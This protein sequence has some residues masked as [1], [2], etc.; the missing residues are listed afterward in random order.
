MLGGFVSND[1]E[2][3]AK[4]KDGLWV[5]SR[6]DVETGTL[7]L[8][9]QERRVVNG[10][11]VITLDENGGIARSTPLAS[12]DWTRDPWVQVV[13]LSVDEWVSTGT[14]PKGLVGKCLRGWM[15]HSSRMLCGGWGDDASEVGSWFEQPW[16][17][18]WMT[19]DVTY[20]VHR[21]LGP[22]KEMDGLKFT[23]DELRDGELEGEI[24]VDGDENPYHLKI[25]YEQIAAWTLISALP[26]V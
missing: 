13:A 10:G 22:Y 20:L 1:K 11:E 21:P 17:G 5:R 8:S 14:I 12:Y 24:L 26:V 2:Y 3:Y 7:S 4:S 23:V 19:Q 15:I 9:W 18:L 16:K 25:L 6:L